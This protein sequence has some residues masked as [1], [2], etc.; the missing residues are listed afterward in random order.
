MYTMTKEELR[1]RA[2]VAALPACIEAVNQVLQL[3]GSLTEKNT[4]EQAAYMAVSYADALVERLN[5]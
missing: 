5:R 2:A 1:R 4:A 3:G